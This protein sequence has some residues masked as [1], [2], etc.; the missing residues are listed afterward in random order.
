MNVLFWASVYIIS[1]LICFILLIKIEKKDR[2]VTIDTLMLFTMMS[3]IWPVFLLFI[4]I[5]LFYNW[6]ENV[7]NK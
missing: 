6:L 5:V 4:G 7:V 3:V 1:V 2:Y